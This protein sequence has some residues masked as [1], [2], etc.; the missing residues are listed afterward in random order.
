[1]LWPGVFMKNKISPR[2]I[3]QMAAVTRKGS[4]TSLQLAKTGKRDLT[5]TFLRVFC[6]LRAC[7]VQRPTTSARDSYICILGDINER[8][9]RLDARDADGGLTFRLCHALINC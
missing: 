3:E 1:M 8:D 2:S 9:L 5:R 6:R 4:L 7:Y